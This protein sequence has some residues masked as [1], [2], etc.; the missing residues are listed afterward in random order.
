MEQLLKEQIDKNNKERKIILHLLKNV[1][2]S[3]LLVLKLFDDI[4]QNVISTKYNIPFNIQSLCLAYGLINC[5]LT[6]DYKQLCLIFDVKQAF[7][8]KKLTKSSY[9][10]IIELLIDNRY[11][12]KI[13]HITIGFDKFIKINLKIDDVFV[14]DIKQFISTNN[15]TKVSDRFKEEMKFKNSRLPYVENDLANFI[16]KVN[17]PY[18]LITNHIKLND[19]VY[20]ALKSDHII[21]NDIKEE[22]LKKNIGKSSLIKKFKPSKEI[23]NFFNFKQYASQAGKRRYT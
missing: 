16:C 1:N 23:Y 11:Y 2:I 6:K 22:D 8:D 5:Y 15:Y 3:T 21:I 17:L 10:N 4:T 9:S 7:K 20:T 12:S 18:R 19:I 14:S 13:S